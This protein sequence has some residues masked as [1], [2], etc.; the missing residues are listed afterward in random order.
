M[1]LYYSWSQTTA[2]HLQ[3]F[4]CAH[5]QRSS[6]HRKGVRR[7]LEPLLGYPGTHLICMWPGEGLGT[8]RG[9]GSTCA[10]SLDSSWVKTSQCNLIWGRVI[11]PRSAG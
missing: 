10:E 1:V 3:E 4:N 2:S 7:V 8:I 9:V 11:T 6:P 5:R